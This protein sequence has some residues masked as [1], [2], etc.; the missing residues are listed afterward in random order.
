MAARDSGLMSPLSEIPLFPLKTVLFPSG[1]LPLRIFEAR[2]VDMVKRC[3]REQQGFGVVLIREGDETGAAEFHEVGTI[4]RIVDFH[5]MPDGL[6]GLMTRGEQRFRVQSHAR[7]R[8]GLNV[9]QVNL[10]EIEV[11]QPLAAEFRPLAELLEKL[12]PELGESYAGIEQRFDD[13]DWVGFRLAE[14]LPL[15]QPSRQFCLELENAEERLK[16]LSG[17]VNPT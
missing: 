15:T 17:V 13:A 12:W 8:D 7:Q 4:A 14:V 1:P 9:G 5:A 16:L 2:Y 6:L 3:L 11:P 10:C